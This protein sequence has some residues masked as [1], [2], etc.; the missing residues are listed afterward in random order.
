MVNHIKTL[1]GIYFYNSTKNSFTSIKTHCLNEHF[2]NQP[3][4]I[5]N[6][7]NENNI[8]DGIEVCKRLNECKPRVGKV[9]NVKSKMMTNEYKYSFS[10]SKDNENRGPS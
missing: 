5:Y 7:V 10:L 6:Y 9:K 1:D 4:K 2:Y 8:S 3:M